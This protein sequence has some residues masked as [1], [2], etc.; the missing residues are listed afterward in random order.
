VFGVN[1]QWEITHQHMDTL[2]DRWEHVVITYEEDDGTVR[3]I[4]F[5]DYIA[6]LSRENAARQIYDLERTTPD[7]YQ[8]LFGGGLSEKE[9]RDALCWFIYMLEMRIA[10]LESQPPH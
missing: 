7:E 10:D 8:Y 9:Y 1:I 2:T 6:S 3:H 5:A 4:C